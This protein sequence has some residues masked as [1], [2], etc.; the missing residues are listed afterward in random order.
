MVVAWL[1]VECGMPMYAQSVYENIKSG[2]ALLELSDSDLSS[3]LAITKTMHRRK[4]R[5]AIE[6]YRQPSRVWV[7]PVTIL[8]NCVVLKQRLC[9]WKFLHKNVWKCMQNRSGD[10]YSICTMWAQS[11]H[12][13]NN[14]WGKWSKDGT[15]LSIMEGTGYKQSTRKGVHKFPKNIWFQVHLF[16]LVHISK[17]V[18]TS[19]GLEIKNED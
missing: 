2:K 6:D 7:K 13:L 9:W 5:L 10:A 14:T 8:L 4:L 11:G 18:Y 16:L 15:W 19:S 17:F 12:I 3:G 1:E